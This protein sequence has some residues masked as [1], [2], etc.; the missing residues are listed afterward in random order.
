M[1]SSTV[2]SSFIFLMFIK[3]FKF[4]VVNSFHLFFMYSGFNILFRMV[5]LTINSSKKLYFLLLL[6]KIFRSYYSSNYMA[7]SSDWNKVLFPNNYH[8]LFY[9]TVDFSFSTKLKCNLSHIL[10]SHID[11]GCF[12]SNSSMPPI[13]FSSETMLF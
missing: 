7:W 5:S 10:N 8:S 1:F 12:Y 3:N 6:F 11:I 13:H 9:L 2:R 4:W